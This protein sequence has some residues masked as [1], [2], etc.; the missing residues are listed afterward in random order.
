MSD[1]QCPQSTVRRSAYSAHDI[2]L[3]LLLLFDAMA[4]VAS[5]GSP[6]QTFSPT[7]NTI[8]SSRLL[9]SFMR[10]ES[11]ECVRVCDNVAANITESR[12]IQIEACDKIEEEMIIHLPAPYTDFLCST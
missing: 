6:S 4:R 9:T 7:G 12:L 11:F 2:R 3:S 1:T 5:R 8:L 10:S